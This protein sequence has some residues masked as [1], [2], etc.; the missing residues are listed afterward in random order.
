ME[1]RC[2]EE[3]KITEKK[4]N[5]IGDTLCDKILWDFYTRECKIGNMRSIGLLCLIHLWTEYRKC[6]FDELASAI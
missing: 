4:N 3:K 5:R 1:R 6:L 2:M